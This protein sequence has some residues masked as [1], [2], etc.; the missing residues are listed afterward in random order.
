MQIAQALTSLN[1]TVDTPTDNIAGHRIAD[2]FSNGGY[3]IGHIGGS[4]SHDFLITGFNSSTMMFDYYE[5]VTGE[6]MQINIGTII[7]EGYQILLFK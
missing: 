5:S 1:F 7:E 3:G 4:P 2:W 6:Y